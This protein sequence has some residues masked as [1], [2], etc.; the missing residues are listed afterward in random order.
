MPRSCTCHP[1]DNP[2]VPCAEKYALTECREAA[3][4]EAKMQ[5]AIDDEVIRQIL[6][7]S[8]ADVLAGRWPPLV[9]SAIPDEE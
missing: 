5:K 3:A 4:R 8:D 7:T 2:P 6:E 1:D 9:Q